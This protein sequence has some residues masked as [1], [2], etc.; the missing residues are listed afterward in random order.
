MFG[1]RLYRDDD[2]QDLQDRVAEGAAMDAYFA[3]MQ[4][5]LAIAEK[6]PA[7]CEDLKPA[8]HSLD[9]SRI[10]WS[11]PRLG[12]EPV[13]VRADRDAPREMSKRWIVFV[14]ARDFYAWWRWSGFYVWPSS[15]LPET[16]RFRPPAFGKISDYYKY[17]DQTH[18]IEGLENPSVLSEVAFREDDGLS[19]S[20]GMTRTMW[21]VANG[22]AIFPVETVNGE[23]EALRMHGRVGYAE[24]PP[25]PLSDL[26]LL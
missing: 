6:V 14:K 20:D 2:L 25:V 21:L 8:V 19:F 11:V 22:A 5:V 24:V 10:V 12:Q 7:A 3:A 26:F 18:W 23:A 16:N 13:Y 1:W 17:D 15:S 9:E 4:E